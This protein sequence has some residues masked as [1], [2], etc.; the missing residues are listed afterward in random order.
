MIKILKSIGLILYFLFIGS[1]IGLI[2]TVMFY[3]C[4]S[5]PNMCML[6]FAGRVIAYIVT[7]LLIVFTS[8]IYYLDNKRT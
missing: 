2:S 4:F 5:H 8:T 1:F 3:I 6:P 7:N